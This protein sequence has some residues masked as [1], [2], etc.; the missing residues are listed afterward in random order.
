MSPTNSFVHQLVK[1]S[2]PAKEGDKVFAV[3]PLIKKNEKLPRGSFGCYTPESH[4]DAEGALEVMEKDIE[5]LKLTAKMQGEEIETMKK[6]HSDQL[7]INAK[8]KES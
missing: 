4:E 8:Q 7:A 2:E 5:S 6:L 3:T 1:V